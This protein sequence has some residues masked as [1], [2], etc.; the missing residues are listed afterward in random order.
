LGI[1]VELQSM[2]Q[3]TNFI[4]QLLF[5]AYSASSTVKTLN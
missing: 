5:F 4:K 3:A 2:S 1:A